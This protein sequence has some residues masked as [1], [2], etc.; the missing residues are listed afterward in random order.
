MSKFDLEKMQGAWRERS[1]QAESSLTLDVE[2]ARNRLKLG[3]RSAFKRHLH[4]LKLELVFGTATL[5]ALLAFIFTHAQ[6]LVYL[7]ATAPLLA[8]TVFAVSADFFHWRLLSKLN[9]SAPI[10]AVRAVIV[11]VR[12]RRL[13]VAKWIALSACLLWLPLVAVLGKALF[14]VDLLRGL[15]F[16]F[17]A[18]NIAFGALLIPIG[19][20]VF[21][22]FTQRFA[23]A[24]TFQRFVENA[25]GASFSAARTS[26]ELEADFESVLDAS[27]QVP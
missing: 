21:R 16:E 27:K 11:S 15:A 2:S 20:A 7:A 19:L 8:L 26:F 17:I 10:V 3:T 23:N 18:A 12:A 1:L 14:G 4:W 24:P 5:I 9:L 25:S 6:D 22:W 13:L